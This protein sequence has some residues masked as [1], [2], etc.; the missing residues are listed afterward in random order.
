MEKELQVSM[1]AEH[2]LLLNEGQTPKKVKKKYH[3]SAMYAANLCRSAIGHVK[4]NS[5]R[6]LNL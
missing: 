2:Q 4:H 6:G 1:P 3:T 5:G